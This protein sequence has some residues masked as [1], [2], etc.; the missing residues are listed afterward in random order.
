MSPQRTGQT[1]RPL[2]RIQ[3]IHE[4]LSAGGYPNCSTLAA[5]LEV[6]TK[7]IQ[8]DLD[9]MRDELARAASYRFTGKGFSNMDSVASQVRS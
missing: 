6:S 5:L 2:A 7:T 4:E 1:R 9:F 8:R 3:R